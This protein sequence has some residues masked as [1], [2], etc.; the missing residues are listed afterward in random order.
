MMRYGYGFP[1]Y[2]MAKLQKNL[3]IPLSAS[4]QWDK[5]EEAADAIYLMVVLI[6]FMTVFFVD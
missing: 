5:I 1:L 4:T 2:R 6:I 3:G